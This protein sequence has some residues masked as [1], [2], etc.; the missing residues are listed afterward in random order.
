MAS[1]ARHRRKSRDRHHLTCHTG[2][3][4]VTD[5]PNEFC[6]LLLRRQHKLEIFRKG[7]A[8]TATQQC[9]SLSREI[10][11]LLSGRGC[12]ARSPFSL[13]GH[14]ALDGYRRPTP[15]FPK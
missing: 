7:A 11:R 5:P 15:T 9:L 8:T 12:I 13:R 1:N 6:G 4:V 3:L 10:N 14:T 2:R